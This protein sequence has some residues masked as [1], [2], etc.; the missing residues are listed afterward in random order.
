[1]PVLEGRA[2][3][4]AEAVVADFFRILRQADTAQGVRP[5]ALPLALFQLSAEQIADL[6]P[7]PIRQDRVAITLFLELQL[8][9]SV[10]DFAA[11][12]SGGRTSAAGNEARGEE[13]DTGEEPPWR[14][15]EDAPR[16]AGG[17]WG[18]HTPR[19]GGGCLDR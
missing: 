17:R 9:D 11:V 2:D 7:L 18:K 15:G 19:G 14:A 12:G 5:K 4:S 1:M 16:A 3:F 13:G 6:P 8:D 10:D